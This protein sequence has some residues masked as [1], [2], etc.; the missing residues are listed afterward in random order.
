MDSSLT[1]AQMREA[2]RR[3]I[4]EVGIP[5]V[6]L[7][8]NAGKAVFD[9]LPPGSVGIVCGKGNNGGDGFVVARYSILA[10]RDTHVVLVGHPESLTPD[11]ETFKKSYE[12]LGGVVTIAA[13]E[14]S[15]SQ[16]ISALRDYDVLVDA[17]LG[18]GTQGDVRGLPRVAIESWPDVDTVAVDIPSGMNGDTGEA[19]G[20]CVTALQTV[21]FQFRKRGFDNPLARQ[22]CGDIIVADIG[23]PAVCEDDDAW[24]ELSKKLG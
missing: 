8:D 15:V 13:T 21:T 18:T 12:K 10:G 7:M 1:V 19:C 23:I 22:W 9:V 20:V 24:N 2:D 17:L 14:E 16:S 11:S 4:E 5:S 3:A 6:V